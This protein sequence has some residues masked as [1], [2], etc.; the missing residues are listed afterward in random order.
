LLYHAGKS[1]DA[2]GGGVGVKDSFST[3]LLESACCLAQLR[4]GGGSVA[5]LSGCLH[6]FRKGFEA[7]FGC[8]VTSMPLQVL[9]VSFFF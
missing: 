9:F 2:A 6:L 3:S 8:L 7:R 1:C 4:L 5:T